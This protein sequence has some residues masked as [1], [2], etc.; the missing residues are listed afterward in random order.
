MAT[1]QIYFLTSDGDVSRKIEIGCADDLDAVSEST[2]LTRNDA[3]EIEIWDRARFVSWQPVVPL[4]RPGPIRQRAMLLTTLLAKSASLAVP[5][6]A[7]I[8]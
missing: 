5:V 1:Y 3:V 7:L 8:K 6:G 2:R 4:P